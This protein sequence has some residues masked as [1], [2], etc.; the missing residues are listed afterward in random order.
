MRHRLA[1]L[2]LLPALLTGC[3][4]LDG[5]DADGGDYVEAEND[6]QVVNIVNMN[7]NGKNLFCIKHGKG[8]SCDWVRYHKENAQ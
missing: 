6:D 5:K 7:V 1:A 2:L 4:S 3:S 8:L